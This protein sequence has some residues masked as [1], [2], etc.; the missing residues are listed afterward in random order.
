MTAYII[1]RVLWFI[2]VLFCVG[3]ITFAIARMTPGGPFDT[4]PN[5]PLPRA[6]QRA[7]EQKFGMHLPWWRQFTRYMFF[8]IETDSRTKERSIRWG[9]IGGNLGPTYASRGAESVQHFLFNSSS[10]RPSRFYYSARLGAQAI[11]FAL[12]VG[13]PLGTIGA[14]R[15]NTWI[16]YLALFIS[17]TFVGIP[18][19]ISSL[20]LIILFAVTLG[21]FT[22]LPDWNDPI[23]PWILPTVGLGFSIMAFITR[24]ARS[25][26]LEVKRQDYVRTARAKGLSDS[27]V[28]IRHV[29]RNAILPIVTI[30]GP[31]TAGLITGAVFTETIFLVPGMGRAF[32]EAIGKRD[33]SM[34][35]GLALFYVF[36]LTLANLA[37]DLAYGAVDP[38]ISTE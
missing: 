11:L 26:V 34:I 30:M 5:R 20:L 17:T 6:T 10:S 19:L 31:L 1:R 23:R 29:L 9:A 36:L 12:I 35:M 32:V 14:L 38:R 22:V 28:N 21:W 33:Y 25:S 15:Q 18:A 24:L 3:L 2:P 4:N 27:V 37:V 8:D 16:D 7:L 13:I